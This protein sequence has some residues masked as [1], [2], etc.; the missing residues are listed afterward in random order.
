[1]ITDKAF[2]E[3]QAKV[4]VLEKMHF[5]E[6]NEIREEQLNILHRQNELTMQVNTLLKEARFLMG[7][8]DEVTS[9]SGVAIPVETPNLKMVMDTLLKIS[10]QL[11][12]LNMRLTTME[13]RAFSTKKA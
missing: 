7:A 8:L 2:M 4:T 3:L 11:S 12:S 6:W 1:M 9:G 13:E 10:K 5:S